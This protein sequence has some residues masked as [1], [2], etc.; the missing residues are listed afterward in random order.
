MTQITNAA[1]SKYRIFISHNK[2]DNELGY[3]LA[4]ELRRILGSK[5]AVWYDSRGGRYNS[6]AGIRPGDNWQKV[7]ADNI[8]SCKIFLLLWSNHAKNADWVRY[9]LSLA[10][11]R[12]AT[13]K[14]QIVP[15]CIDGCKLP[16]DLEGIQYINYTSG[17]DYQ[18][19]LDGIRRFL[20]LP[21][22]TID[23][24]TRA[25]KQAI[26]E[27]QDAFHHK[28]WQIVSQHYLM[29]TEL[30]PEAVSSSIH[31]MFAIAMIEQGQ[32][33]QAK[34]I[35]TRGLT[36]DQDEHSSHLLHDYAK[37]IMS[38]Q[39]WQELQSL[40]KQ[41]IQMFPQD[42]YW[43]PLLRQAYTSLNSRPDSSFF[44][45][46]A[47]FTHTTNTIGSNKGLPIFNQSDL[48]PPLEPNPYNNPNAL[49]INDPS[50]TIKL[51]TTDSSDP[52]RTRILNVD[53][54]TLESEMEQQQFEDP[55]YTKSG[56][57]YSMTAFTEQHLADH[58]LSKLWT[59]LWIFTL[60]I[61]LS[62]LPL[63]F[64]VFTLP[65]LLIPASVATL[66][67]V[68]A[69]GKIF[70]NS[71]GQVLAF[72]ASFFWGIAGY[73]LSYY[74]YHLFSWT[75]QAMLTIW[76]EWVCIIL[77]WAGGLGWHLRLFRT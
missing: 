46:Q 31:Y 52:L 57:L 44:T 64:S 38:K 20:K 36:L 43:Y 12:G 29:L 9:E 32:L 28:E 42:P 55:T 18:G 72:P 24:R 48:L 74:L 19:V 3:W 69:L 1:P 17:E 59:P 45:N 8:R 23:H 22:E 58:K 40:A 39:M 2:A 67:F 30:F 34:Q 49:Y 37:I 35:L 25:W 53:Q 4:D 33:A 54:T 16:F 47:Q 68:Q 62:L 73:C 5:D 26:F 27:M 51:D 10:K 63:I 7:I 65:A 76:L 41:A 13:G 71:L 77:C 56:K 75:P 15:I 61:N 14:L 66:F 50:A 70:G 60:I 21:A 6:R 11:P